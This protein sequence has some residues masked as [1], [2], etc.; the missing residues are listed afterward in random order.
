MKY[1][2]LAAVLALSAQAGRDCAISAV[3]CST[4]IVL[5]HG[6]FVDRSGQASI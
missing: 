6:G 5:V 3:D 1:H 2:A 4:T